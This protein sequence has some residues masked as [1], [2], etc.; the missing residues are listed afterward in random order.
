MTDL[1]SRFEELFVDEPPAPD[2]LDRIVV[3][4]QRSLR[5]RRLTTATLGTVG[6]AAA[7]AAIVVPLSLTGTSGQGHSVIRVGTHPFAS[8]SPSPDATSRCR[9][10]EPAA[11]LHAALR[12]ARPGLTVLRKNGR[13]YWLEC[14]DGTSASTKPVTP[15]QPPQPRYHYSEAPSAIAARLGDLLSRRVSGFGLTVN[16]TRPFSQETSTLESGHPA[17]YGGNVDVRESHGYGDIGVQVTHRST[18]QVPLTGSCSPSP[19]ADCHQTTL[20]DGSVLRTARVSA[21]GKNVVLTAELSRPNGLLVQAQESNYA[22]GPQAGTEARGHQPITLAQLVSL[23][24]D[25]GFAF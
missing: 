18:R 5:R 17:Y 21:G 13:T 6:A 3:S 25:Q 8:P 10:R 24:D 16:Y 7:T 4:G 19:P 20:P 1:K 12:T 14:P 15:P 23:A 22:F 2:D 11:A 9:V